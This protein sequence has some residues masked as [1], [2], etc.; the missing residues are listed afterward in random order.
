MRN[1]NSVKQQNKRYKVTPVWQPYTRWYN[2]LVNLRG[3]R[4]LDYGCNIESGFHHKFLADNG[5]ARTG[6]AAYFGYDIDED[7]LR[8][9]KD[10]KLYYDFFADNSM[11]EGLDVVNAS[12]V[13]EHLTPAERASF[14]RRAHDLLRPDGVLM[15]D[16]PYI[17]NLNHLYHFE[18]IT[19]KPVGCGQEAA[20]INTFGFD[21]KLYLTGLTIPY[22][23]LQTNIAEFVLNMVLGYYPFHTTVIVARTLPLLRAAAV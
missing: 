18:D 23:S 13:Y 10:N 4:C 19:H 11:L 2:N 3:L 22:K 21:C 5:N 12:Q 9:A 17:S 16:F 6:Q 15:L 1:Y 14:L 20:F 7:S 8:W